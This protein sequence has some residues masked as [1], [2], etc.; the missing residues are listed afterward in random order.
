MG[1]IDS[2][3]TNVR[4]D[5]VQK[6]ECETSNSDRKKILIKK[7]TKTLDYWFAKRYDSVR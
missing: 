4:D 2:D 3:E 6:P 5:A 1:L 7:K